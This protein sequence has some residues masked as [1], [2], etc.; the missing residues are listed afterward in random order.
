M[1]ETEHLKLT[2]V[3]DYRRIG[4]AQWSVTCKLCGRLL[5]GVEEGLTEHLPSHGVKG[6]GPEIE[7]GAQEAYDKTYPL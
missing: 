2:K 1:V 7:A 3:K 4:K 6:Y 5:S